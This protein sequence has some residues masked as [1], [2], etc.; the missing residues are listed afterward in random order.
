VNHPEYPSAHGFFSNAI[1]EAVANYFHTKKL[2]WRLQTSKEAVPQLIQT[3]RTFHD[4]R[5]IGKQVDNARVWAGLHWRH[6]M[7]DGDQIGREV[8]KRVFVNYFRPI[9]KND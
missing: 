5:D 4:L 2:T 3:E 6:S 7:H 1:L 9:Q 8:A